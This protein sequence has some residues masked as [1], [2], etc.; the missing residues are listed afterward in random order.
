MAELEHCEIKCASC[1]FH[2]YRDIWKPNNEHEQWNVYD[3]FAMAFKVKSV[4]MLAI[5][6][7]AQ[8]PREIS[9]FC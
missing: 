2:V 5:T 9:R 6:V 8:V 4:A 7:I 3:P 1:G